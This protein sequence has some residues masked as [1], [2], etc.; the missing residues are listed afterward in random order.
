MI[1][2]FTT[3]IQGLMKQIQTKQEEAIEDGA[4]L[5]AQA[6][7]GDGFIYIHGDLE[8]K[9]V[10]MEALYGADQLPHIKP[11][12]VNGQL[13]DVGMNDR[14]LYISRNSEEPKAIETLKPLSEK[15]IPI[16]AMGTVFDEDEQD[17]VHHLADVFINLQVKRSLVPLDDGTRIG[18][19]ASLVALYTF[20]YLSLTLKEILAEY[21]DE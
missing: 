21:A 8:M 6:R 17:S 9:A 3:Q 7:V 13:A 20:F 10:E 16:V 11:L 19:P 1:Q 5:L 18:Y 14:I 2:I 4:R 12:Q 15:G